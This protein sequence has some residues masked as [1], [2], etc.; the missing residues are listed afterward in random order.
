M[1]I[2]KLDLCVTIFAVQVSDELLA[3][4]CVVVFAVGVEKGDMIVRVARFLLDIAVVRVVLVDLDNRV[5]LKL[6]LGE[7]LADLRCH[8]RLDGRMLLLLLLL[9]L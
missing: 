7:L 1:Q 8:N 2:N 9:L 3:R 6:G 5:N 4:R